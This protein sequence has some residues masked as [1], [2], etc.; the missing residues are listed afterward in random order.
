MCSVTVQLPWP[1]TANHYWKR[2]GNIYFISKAGLYYRLTT[3]STCF[4]FKGLFTSKQRLKVVV[5]AFPPDRRRRDLDNLC[6]C[7]L[8]SLQ[9]AGVYADDSQIDYLLVVRRPE[10]LNKVSV[11]IEEIAR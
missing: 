1:P 8:D 2:N 5:E 10:L 9:K 11:T 7:L 4:N 6:K 3:S